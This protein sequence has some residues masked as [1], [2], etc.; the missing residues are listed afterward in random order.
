M[1]TLQFEEVISHAEFIRLDQIPGISVDLRYA[2]TN[3][4]VGRKLYAQ[5]DCS[6]LHRIAAHALGQA[7]LQ[8]SSKNYSLLVLDALRPQ[9]IQEQMWDALQGTD[10]IQYLAE[11]KRGSI[12][13]YGMA[14][15]VTLLDADGCEVDMGSGFDA[16]VDTSHTDREPQLLA[17]KRLTSAQYNHRLLLRSAMQS[18]GY[19]S[20]ST[21]WWH[22]DC[23]DR[24]QVR[25]TMARVL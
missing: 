21:E 3:N 5:I 14:V 8:L 9:R 12:H 7:A 13:S 24:A 16:M 4:F 23:G 15:D 22:F 10:L 17:E 20:I 25:A 2:S 19:Q 1:R 11:P 6:Y 18:A